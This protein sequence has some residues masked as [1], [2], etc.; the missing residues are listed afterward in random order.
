VK[1]PFIC[2]HALDRS[3][4]NSPFFD[5]NMNKS[6]YGLLLIVDF[7]LLSTALVDIQLLKRDTLIP[8]PLYLK[9]FL[10]VYLVWFIVIISM[11]KFDQF[12]VNSLYDN[13]LL[14]FKSNIIFT[15]LISLVIVGFALIEISRLQTY[16]TCLLFFLL[17]VGATIAYCLYTGKKVSWRRP[18]LT[19]IDTHRQ[20]IS[21][22][23]MIMDGVLL[24]V[25]FEIINLLKTRTLDIPIEYEPVLVFIFGFWLLTSLL[26]HK[27]D[28]DNFS[29]YFNA[30]VPCLKS[31]AIMMATLAV[32]V[33]A[34]RLFYFSRL[35]IFGSL[36]ILLLLET[37]L[38]YLYFIYAKYKKVNIDIE[39]I[40]QVKA[41]LEREK[42]RE[43]APV[44]ESDPVKDPAEDKLRGTM[45]DPN[46]DLFNFIRD[47]ID[48]S[49]ISNSDTA[50]LST[51]NPFNVEVLDPGRLKLF[52]NLHKLND[53]RRFNQYFL[54]VHSK[55]MAGG[56]IVGMANTIT[57]YRLSFMRKY[58]RFLAHVLYGISFIW[59]R[60]FPKLP[61]L[62]KVYFVITKGRSR[63]VSKA[64]VLG[65]LYFCGF[66]VVAEKEIG[67][68]LFYIARKLMAP[69]VDK[70]PTY[71]PIIR[72]NRIGL[73]SH[74]IEVHK[75]RT[76]H[77]YAE[78][79]QDYIYEHY[80]LQKGGK[81]ASDFRIPAWG[82][83]LRKYWIDELP[84][85]YN[86]I[87][88]ELKLFGIR[89]L[90]RQY[91]ELY[92]DELKALRVKVKPGLIPPFYADMPETLEMI[93]ESELRYLKAYLESPASTQIR[94][95]FKTIY[96]I[97]FKGARSH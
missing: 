87:K 48:I 49:S 26:T 16:G 54:L 3:E 28:R 27:Y 61:L 6:G 41:I 31:F 50:I 66:K 7:V 40:E 4:V 17:E 23:L 21:Y 38:Y 43:I 94:Y 85:L 14:V 11:K 9:F 5:Q 35:R 67:N 37:G 78:Y 71:G 63:L 97:V 58:P 42:R 65:R 10:I 70:S 82:H 95:F 76:M 81:F 60:L 12:K 13:L 32:I 44:P 52:I 80:R 96:N 90:S 45:Q 74:I 59:Y 15:Y 51:R 55:L 69:A 86:W 92:S 79:L 72:L 33:F 91:L 25:G 56:Y 8:T 19:Y 88:G 30:L 73:N 62:Q 57:T 24:F 39:S 22:L 89:P 2:K 93:I 18:D 68:R 77:P 36:S 83:F 64:E 29:D 1:K 34:F 53:I 75:F 46:P 20:D 47:N 84:M